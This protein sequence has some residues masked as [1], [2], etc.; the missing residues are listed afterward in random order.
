MSGKCCTGES[1]VSIVG[2]LLYI[3]ATRY[4]KW[5]SLW[6]AVEE[7]VAFLKIHIME[8]ADT[9]LSAFSCTI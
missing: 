9:C 8:N 1:V 2:Y 5:N 4:Y 6:A 3:T 7:K